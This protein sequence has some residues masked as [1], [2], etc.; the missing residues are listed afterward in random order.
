MYFGPQYCTQHEKEHTNTQI[1][2][3]TYTER[4]RERGR[5]GVPEREQNEIEAMIEEKT[6]LLWTESFQFAFNLVYY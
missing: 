3:H 5:E 4:D 6:S 2:A 1:C